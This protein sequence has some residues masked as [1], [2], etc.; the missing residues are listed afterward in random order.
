[1]RSKN[2]G[3][4]AQVLDHLPSLICSTMRKN[5]EDF[6]FKPYNRFLEITE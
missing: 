2:S 4:V 6:K 5:D 3:D 1:M